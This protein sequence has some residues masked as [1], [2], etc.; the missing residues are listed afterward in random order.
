[1]STRPGMFIGNMEYAVE[2]GM[3]NVGEPAPDFRLTAN[4]W[5][6][7]SLADYAGKVKILSIVPSLDTRVCSAQTRR[8]NEEASA[9]GDNVVVLTV[10]ADLPYAQRRWCGAEGIER[11]VTLSDH[12]DMSFSTAY[13]VH[14]PDLRICQRGCFVLDKDNIIRHAEYTPVMGNEINFIAAL[15]TVQKLI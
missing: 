4:D 3:L 13:G 8:F 5:T 1:M 14:V 10:S 11:V 7:K 12:K 6:M 9:F 2:G 15:S